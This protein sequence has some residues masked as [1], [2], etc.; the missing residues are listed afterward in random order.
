MAVVGKEATSVGVGVRVGVNVHVG[1]S[2]GIGPVKKV[3]YSE[4]WKV[5]VVDELENVTGNVPKV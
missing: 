4:K 5:P 1:V 3:A 2:V